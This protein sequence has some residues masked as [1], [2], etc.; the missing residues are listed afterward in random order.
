MP[1]YIILDY[2]GTLHN[3]MHI[4]KKAFLEAYAWLVGEGRAQGREFADE[5]ISCWLGY[6]SKEMWNTFMPELEEPLKQRVSAMIGKSMVRR[7]TSGEAVLYPGA[8]EALK[9]LKEQGF[10]LIFLSNCKEAYMEANRVCF[11]LDAYFDAFYCCETY[12]FLPKGKII[13]DILRHYPGKYLAAGDRASDY[14]AAREHGIPFIGCTYGFG[15]AEELA[16]ANL[17]AQNVLEIPICAKKMLHPS[18]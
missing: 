8:L 4:Y 11:N 3:T 9:L 7:I 6:N 16:D 2:D 1:D 12:Q 13:S 14:E 18:V 5:Q 17:L 10:H 15:T